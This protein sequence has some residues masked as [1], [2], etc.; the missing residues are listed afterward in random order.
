MKTNINDSYGYMRLT[1]SLAVCWGLPITRKQITNEIL[2]RDSDVQG[3]IIIIKTIS[4]F[5]Y[6]TKEQYLL[7]TVC[8]INKN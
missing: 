8:K 1:H 6:S 4:S 3:N 5:E 2:Y 7:S